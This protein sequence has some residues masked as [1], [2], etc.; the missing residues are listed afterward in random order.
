MAKKEN[1]KSKK[2]RDFFIPITPS[3]FNLISSGL[4]EMEQFRHFIMV[5]IED[6]KKSVEKRFIKMTEG[7]SEEE[8]EHFADWYGEDYH[9][10]DK[11]F[12]NIGLNSFVLILYSHLESSLNSICDS[13]FSDQRLRCKR[14]GGNPVNLK[15]TDMKGKG[16]LRAKL[17][18]EKVFGADLH[19]GNI[20]WAEI[21]ALQKIRNVIV[22][23]EGWVTTEIMNDPR[24]K[25]CLKKGQLEIIQRS[26][27]TPGMINIKPEYLDRI[28]KQARIFFQ[29]ITLD[30]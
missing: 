22:H 19:P 26:K 7:M 3:V 14:Q 6:E 12:T 11:A 24:I 16:I 2:R 28:L 23:D 18:L 27:D 5:A 1:K 25:D 9:M 4:D 13:M 17:Y 15:Y 10:V 20:P 30:Y 8:A 21:R 29:K